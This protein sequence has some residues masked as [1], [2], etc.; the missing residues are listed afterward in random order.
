[1]TLTDPAWSQPGLF[2]PDVVEITLRV[3]V[4]RSQDHLQW[5]LEASN[6]TDGTLMRLESCPHRVM[7]QAADALAQM[8]RQLAL[9]LDEV[10]GPF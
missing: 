9:A 5:Q 8:G 1:M 2:P 3:G 6:A 7:A 10:C 4:V